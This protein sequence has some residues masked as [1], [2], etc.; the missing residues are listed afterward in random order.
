MKGWRTAI[1]QCK[2]L[3]FI[4]IRSRILNFYIGE[5]AAEHIA[6]PNTRLDEGCNLI[7]VIMLFKKD[8]NVWPSSVVSLLKVT[9]LLFVGMYIKIMDVI[10]W[11]DIGLKCKFKNAQVIV[12]TKQISVG[13]PKYIVFKKNLHLLPANYWSVT[14]AFL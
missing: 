5:M 6:D 2:I 11:L 1:L 13:N 8:C 7:Y 9:V 10:S 4:G 14:W 12:A 3:I